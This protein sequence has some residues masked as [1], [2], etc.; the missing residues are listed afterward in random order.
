MH[1]AVGVHDLAR[2][3]VDTHRLRVTAE[4]H[5]R[6][7]PQRR[8]AKGE[9]VGVLAGEVVVSAT[10]SYGARGSSARTVTA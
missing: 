7:V 6:V 1:H 5:E 8:V 9:V 2:L 4:R 10:L 3:A